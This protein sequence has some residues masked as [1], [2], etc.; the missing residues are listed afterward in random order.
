MENDWPL[1][2][3]CGSVTQNKKKKREREKTIHTLAA[4]VQWSLYR[5]LVHITYIHLSLSSLCILLFSFLFFN[6]I[7]CL[8][9]Y[10]SY[11]SP[12]YVCGL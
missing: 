1:K 5:F 6:T 12:V 7:Y 3:H 8:V 2:S 10:I 11:F 9:S 4:M